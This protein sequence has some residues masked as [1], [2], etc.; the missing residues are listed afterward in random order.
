M[1]A[2]KGRGVGAGWAAAG[3]QRKFAVIAAGLLLATSVLFLLLVISSYRNRILAAQEHASTNVNLLLQ[4]SLENAMIKRDLEGLQGIVR[5]LGAQQGIDGVMI[6]SPDGQIRFSSYEER[7]YQPFTD[8]GLAR[9]LSTRTQQTGFRTLANGAEVLRSI[10]P[11]H[12]KP[13]CRQCHGD[14]SAHPVNGVL[15]VDYDSSGVRRETRQGALL[16]GGLG[17]VVLLTLEFGLWLALRRLVI[18]KIAVLTRATGAVAEGDLSARADMRGDDEI[19]RLGGGFNTMAARLE[20]AMTDLKS[21]EAFLQALIDA[22]PDGVRVIDSDFRIRMANRTYREQ[23]GA[24][25]GEVLGQACYASSHKRNAPCVATLVECPVV[26]CVHGDAAHLKCSHVHVTETGGKLPVEVYAAPATMV[27][28]GQSVDCVVESI[29][30][31]ETQLNIS[32]EQRL[33]E[34]GMLAAGVAHEVHN[35][36]SSIALA[37]RA[38]G[39]Q[40][41]QTD[42]ARRYIG[43]AETEIGNCQAITEALL[44]LAAPSQR[45]PELVDLARVIADTRSLLSFE[46]ERVGIE[47]IA[48]VEGT[49]RVLAS[50]SDMR[51]LVFNLLHNTIHAMPKG[52][53]ARIEC[54]VSGARLRLVV[55]D[56]GV[57]IAARDRE[58]I[59]LPFWTRRADGTSGRG[60]GLAIVKTIVDG[61]GGSVQ[62]ESVLGEGARFII[63]LPSADGADA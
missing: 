53:T 21:S 43:I 61:L 19:A 31:L 24:R 49:P 22:V 12:N 2:G 58:K 52:G 42:E 50:D 59:M 25:Q 26:R 7:L 6:V 8:A 54:R 55:S 38:I 3:L 5:R 39:A 11:V 10:N 16:L 45:A 33:S 17:F 20:T 63:D 56:T 15:V 57:G 18:D 28:D 47:M 46:A 14:M 4:A 36:L 48:D 30:D 40:S 29:R 9:A 41:G 35:P 51:I 23:I 13:E 62:I 27:I 34:M 1:N 44:R 60:L 37:L 32:Q